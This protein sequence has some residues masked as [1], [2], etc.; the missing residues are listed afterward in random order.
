[1]ADTAWVEPVEFLPFVTNIRW[2]I[3]I[4]R[5]PTNCNEYQRQLSSEGRAGQSADSDVRKAIKVGTWLRFMWRCVTTKPEGVSEGTTIN[6]GIAHD[7]HSNDNNNT[8]EQTSRLFCGSF[9]FPQTRPCTYRTE[10]FITLLCVNLYL[11]S[12]VPSSVSD[13]NLTITVNTAGQTV[14]NSQRTQRS[15]SH[16]LTAATS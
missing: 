10:R 8:E 14:H 7:H 5:H 2:P 11:R 9:T 16:T 4:K 3:S 6:V 12:T 13:W 1:M 15:S